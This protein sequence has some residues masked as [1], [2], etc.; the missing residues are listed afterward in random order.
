VRDATD[1]LG[2][3][4]DFYNNRRLH[5]ILDYRIPAEVYFENQFRCFAGRRRRCFRLRSVCVGLWA[6]SNCEF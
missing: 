3:Y 2:G 4:F 1:G 5:R 6:T